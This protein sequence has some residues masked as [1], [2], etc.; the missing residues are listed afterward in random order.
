MAHRVSEVRSVC[1]S[2]ISGNSVVGEKALERKREQ[3]MSVRGTARAIIKS[4]QMESCAQLKTARLLLLRDR[5]C[6]EER[7]LSR[8]R[9]RRIALEQNLAALPP[10]STSSK[11]IA[12]SVLGG[13]HHLY[14]HA[15]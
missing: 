1:A 14:R 9:M 3:G 5:D 4:C 7:I 10:R 6:S 2:A 12:E 13:L 11:I 8:R 15:T